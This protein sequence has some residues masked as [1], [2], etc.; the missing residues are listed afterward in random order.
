MAISEHSEE[1]VCKVCKVQLDK[2]SET[3]MLTKKEFFI[4]HH[5]K[6]AINI[7]FPLQMD[8]GDV[9]MVPAYRVQYNDARGPTKG[10]I[11]FHPDVHLEEVKELA[12]LMTFKC[13]VANIPY[14]G[15]K[16]GVRIDAKKLSQSELERLSRAY[17]REFA[18]FI[19]PDVDIPAP[20]VN[21]TPQIMGWMMDEYE[22]V[23]GKS[24]PSVITGKPVPLGGSL[25]RDYSTSMGAFFVLEAYLKKMKAK[26]PLTVAIQGFGNAGYHMARLCFEHGYK[27]VG[28]SDSKGGVYQSKGLDVPAIKQ[29]KD[30]DDSFRNVKGGNQITNEQLLE[31]PVDI[32]VPAALGNVIHEKNAGKIR[33]SIVLEIANGPV[34]PKADD[35]LQKKNVVV[36]PDI[37][38]NSGGVIVSY[39]EWVQNRMQF[40]WKEQEVNEKLREHIITAFDDIWNTSQKSRETLRKAAYSLAI[41]RILEAE[42]LRG[43]LPDRAKLF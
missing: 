33:A 36:I 4:L 32:L 43:N 12:F 41:H 9:Q 29:I 14:G 13:A 6:R 1:T 8:N 38:A 20:D 27:I 7:N 15:A 19:G 37:L 28:V 35:I 23:C 26:K 10:G 2:V 3:S 42:R 40:Y 5:P 25:G 24:T 16:G 34:T 21:T 22:K 11:R 30:K 17:I 31:L 39:F 18:K